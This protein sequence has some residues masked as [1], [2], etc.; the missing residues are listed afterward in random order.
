MSLIKR[1]SGKSIKIK[2]LIDSFEHQHIASSFSMEQTIAF[3][4][5]PFYIESQSLLNPD[6]NTN[7]CRHIS[8]KDFRILVQSLFFEKRFHHLYFLKPFPN[9][10][11]F[12][13]IRLNQTFDLFMIDSNRCY[14]VFKNETN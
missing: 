14:F 8:L 4:N 11:L 12:E 2:I 6:V 13:A 3:C 10:I 7:G 1:V 5:P 9:N